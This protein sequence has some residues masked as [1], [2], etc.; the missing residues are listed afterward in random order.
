MSRA[1]GILP[2]QRNASSRSREEVSQDVER[3]PLALAVAGLQDSGKLPQR[4]PKPRPREQV[5]QY[6]ASLG[7][8]ILLIAEH[9]QNKPKTCAGEDKRLGRRE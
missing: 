6:G 7:R 3:A 9:R 8:R 4:A 2:Y 1:G 5:L